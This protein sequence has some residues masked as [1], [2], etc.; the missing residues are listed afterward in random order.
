M[1][2][3]V[4]ARA[5]DT[6]HTPAVPVTRT[7]WPRLESQV[8]EAVDSFVAEAVKET[9][10]LGAKYPGLLGIPPPASATVPG[11][12]DSKWIAESGHDLSAA[13][14]ARASL[15][16]A[17][18][19]ATRLDASELARV[20]EPL[21][22]LW[23]QRATADAV[24]ASTTQALTDNA[25]A[26]DRVKRLLEETV[27]T[28]LPERTG[29]ARGPERSR[30]EEL[31]LFRRLVWLD[32]QADRLQSAAIR[33]IELLVTLAYLSLFRPEYASTNTQAQEAKAPVTVRPLVGQ[34]A[35]QVARTSTLKVTGAA[36]E[37]K[38][39]PAAMPRAKWNVSG[40]RPQVP[41]TLGEQ[42][43]LAAK[44]LRDA[45]ILRTR[46]LTAEHA[47]ALGRGDDV[48]L[49]RRLRDQLVLQH[50]REATFDASVITLAPEVAFYGPV[51]PL[52]VR[53]SLGRFWQRANELGC[54]ITVPQLAVFMGRL[55]STA[56]QQLYPG[57]TATTRPGAALVPVGQD[58]LATPLFFTEDAGRSLGQ[59]TGDSTLCRRGLFAVDAVARHSTGAPKVHGCAELTDI[60]GAFLA[61]RGLTVCQWLAVE[62]TASLPG[63]RDLVYGS[64]STRRGADRLE[65][66]EVSVFFAPEAL[67]GS[68]TH[69]SVFAGRDLSEAIDSPAA[70]KVRPLV[71]GAKDLEQQGARIRREAQRQA[72]FANRGFAPWVRR[73]ELRRA[74]TARAVEFVGP[75][76][77][78][79]R[80]GQGAGSTVYQPASRSGTAGRVRGAGEA[81]PAGPAGPAESKEEAPHRRSRSRSRSRGRTDSPS[82]SPSH[83]LHKAASAGHR[84]VPV[85]VALLLM[86]A[87]D[88]TVAAWLI[89]AP[90]TVPELTEV[91]RQ[92]VLLVQGVAAYGW[93]GD[94]KLDNLGLVF[95]QG[96]G[97]A[98]AVAFNRPLNRIPGTLRPSVGLVPLSGGTR[99][100]AEV[101]AE[102]EAAAA[103]L[104]HAGR[105]P[106]AE[107]TD[108]DLREPLAVC[109]DNWLDDIERRPLHCPGITQGFGA[110]AG[111]GAAVETGAGAG[112]GTGAGTGTSLGVGSHGPAY[113]RPTG[114]P[115]SS[116]PGRGLRLAALAWAA[117]PP[118]FQVLG[119]DWATSHFYPE[120]T[121]ASER[122][123]FV[124][125]LRLLW[126]VGYEEWHATQQADEETRVAEQQ[127]LIAAARNLGTL[128]RLLQAAAQ[129]VL[130]GVGLPMA[131]LGWPKLFASL[132][133]EPEAPLLAQVNKI[134]H[135]EQSRLRLVAR[136]A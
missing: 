38:A 9:G 119:L 101:E 98:H 74:A 46:K 18:H 14:L 47:E 60:V 91:A 54:R 52:R 89:E 105:E 51:P 100:E 49:I 8:S 99:V 94:L 44:P 68:G 67:L 125:W 15:F 62:L 77:Q 28:L 19:L 84:S 2:P 85:N 131:M 107:E 6:R 40:S 1:T 11:P 69:A 27:G 23:A 78:V 117:T 86:D 114:P 82:R 58:H 13:Q 81:G 59:L 130:V 113:P 22:S 39:V 30:D 128:R 76:P 87:V 90:R 124:D 110:E 4:A 122:T 93:H 108:T 42:Q 116:L 64:W 31:Q 126:S 17:Q 53:D 45:E 34:T 120:S 21:Q 12:A 115:V 55:V 57:T 97:L 73:A 88:T 103:A 129:P 79:V 5:T 16:T 127:R 72:F 61:G 65:P 32:A 35:A 133:Q 41:L 83:G 75:E 95:A 106:S 123:G 132:F 63:E 136:R 20:A 10:A 56:A 24:R 48:L 33:R 102:A 37:A 118:K 25:D 121:V 71:L 26:F 43:A 66:S 96:P 70:L 7:P 109:V 135:D 112:S 134:Y 3:R 50:I 111:A 92:I 104:A 80:I 36:G 29:A